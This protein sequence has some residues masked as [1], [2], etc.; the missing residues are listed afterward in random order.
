MIYL[1][2]AD[3]IAKTLT[4][5]AQEHPKTAK[6]LQQ[7]AGYFHKNQH[8]MDYLEMRIDFFPIGI[9]MA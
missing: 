7:Q 8:R 6:E 9:G 1:G 5:K 2:H 3:H 4:R